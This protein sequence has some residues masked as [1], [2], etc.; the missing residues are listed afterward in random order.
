MATGNVNKSSRFVCHNTGNN[1]EWRAQHK[2][3]QT[4]ASVFIGP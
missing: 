3:I 4:A 2:D 1:K